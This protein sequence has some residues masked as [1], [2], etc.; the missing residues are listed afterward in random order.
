MV[1]Q[2]DHQLNM[3]LMRFK[4]YCIQVISC[5]SG[6]KIICLEWVSWGNP[7]QLYEPE[8]FIHITDDQNAFERLFLSFLYKHKMT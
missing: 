5:L 8:E 1:F 2:L 4:C 3:S 7:I 6:I